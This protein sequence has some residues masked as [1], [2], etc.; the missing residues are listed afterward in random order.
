M[1]EWWNRNWILVMFVALF[2]AGCALIAVVN[3]TGF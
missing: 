1:N 3:G 2:V